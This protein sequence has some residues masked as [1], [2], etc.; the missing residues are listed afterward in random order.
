MR[1]ELM[2]PRFLLASCLLLPASAIADEA[3]SL[4]P[5]DHKFLSEER[6]VDTFMRDE[7]RGVEQAEDDLDRARRELEEAEQAGAPEEELVELRESVETAEQELGETQGGFDEEL[8]RTTLLVGELSSEQ[9][10]ALNRSLNNT[11]A[12]D[13]IVQI[14]SDE[15]DRILDGDLDKRQI[16]ALTQGYEQEARFDE[17]AR[18]FEA[19]F[20]ETG[21]QKLLDQS[22]RFSEKAESQK[23]KFLDKI[24]DFE[25]ADADNGDDA[26]DEARRSASEAS[27]D[28]AKQ[29]TRRSAAHAARFAAKDAARNA[30]RDSAS[31]EAR[32]AASRAARSATK[33]VEKGSAKGRGKGRKP[34]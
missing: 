21:D 12:S 29:N 20:D 7:Q 31:K 17:K 33:D 24:D 13:L 28:S 19:L 10:F 16:N 15:L 34:R 6:L 2:L 26:G 1:R 30:T 9:L 25:R 27:H 23:Q 4:P 22:L 18:K 8:A 14:D 11:L 32:R 3:D 5:E